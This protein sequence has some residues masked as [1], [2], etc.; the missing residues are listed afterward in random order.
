[1]EAEEGEIG[2]PKEGVQQLAESMRAVFAEMNLPR[3]QI[4]TMRQEMA[5][6][7]EQMAASKFQ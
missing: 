6:L 7:H 4:Q 2:E 1:M 5:R 3:D